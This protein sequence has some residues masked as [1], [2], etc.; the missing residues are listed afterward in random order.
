MTLL[1]QQ[2]FMAYAELLRQDHLYEPDEYRSLRLPIC[3]VYECMAWLSVFW[4][5]EDCGK[6][7][8]ARSA[9]WKRSHDMHP[10]DGENSSP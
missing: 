3:E 10:K 9:A 5:T 4:S 8:L 6:A 7:D 1:E 2:P